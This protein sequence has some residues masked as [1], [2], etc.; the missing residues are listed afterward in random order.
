[1]TALNLNQ[2]PTNITTVEQLTVWCHTV[3]NN[4]YPGET[5]LEEPGR[6][7]IACQTYISP[8]FVNSVAS[9]REIS[10][11]SIGIN[12]NYQATGKVWQYAQDLGVVSVPTAFST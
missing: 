12:K 1:M 5:V 3:L 11:F 7:V 10:R 9:L 2:I 4:L 6:A 8:I